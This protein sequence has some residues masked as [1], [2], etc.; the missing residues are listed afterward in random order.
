M[1]GGALEG[2]AD[3]QGG[4]FV[5]GHVGD[6]LALEHDAAVFD[7]IAG[8]AQDGHE[9]RGF[10]RAVGSEKHMGLAGLD[11]QVNVAQKQLACQLHLQVFDEQHGPYTPSRPV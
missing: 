3:A 7:H 2:H 9:Q 1:V 10:A 4:P 8:H 5:D 11:L 6:V